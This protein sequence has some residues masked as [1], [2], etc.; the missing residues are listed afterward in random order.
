MIDLRKARLIVMAAVLSG[1]A[2]PQ[3]A[4]ASAVMPTQEQNESGVVYITGGIAEEAEVMRGIA[5]Q[6]T[7]EMAFVQ[8]LKQQEEFISEVAVKLENAKKE[9]VLDTVTKGPYLFANVPSGRYTVIAAFNGV[10][11]R[12]HVVVNAKKHQKI[13]FW[14]PI[15]ELPLPEDSSMPAE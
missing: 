11:K 1:W 10:E 7:L 9:V 2:L 13:V 3:Y 12:Q 14:W 15:T 8:K 5:K 6:Y 4:G